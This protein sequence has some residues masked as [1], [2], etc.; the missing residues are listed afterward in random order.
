LVNVKT[1]CA[2]STPTPQLAHR[3]TDKPPSLGRCVPNRCVPNLD[4][5][6][7]LVIPL[8]CYPS[9]PIIRSDRPKGSG[10]IGQGPVLQ[11]TH[12]PRNTLSKGRI[13]KET[14]HPRI[15]VR[16][17]LGQG[18]NNIALKLGISGCKEGMYS[19]STVQYRRR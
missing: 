11:R 19:Y 13:I 9:Y 6:E 16:K 15:F 3:E 14:E 7:I 17:Q 12:R 5:I 1:W 8:H 18:Q 4:R 2:Q 10:H